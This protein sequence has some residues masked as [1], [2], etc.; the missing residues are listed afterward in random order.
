MKRHNHLF[1]KIIEEGNFRQAYCNAIKGKRHKKDVARFMVNWESNLETL[2]Q[3]VITETYKISKYH[4]FK[5]WSGHKWRDIYKLP[6]RDRIVQHAIMRV[7]KPLFI[8][9]FIKDT[10]SSI[11]GRGIHKGLKRVKGALT[12]VEG[13]QYCLK[14][15]VK[16]FYPNIDQTILKNKLVKRFKDKKLLRLL[17]EIIDSHPQG[18]PI[19][20]YTSQYFANFFLSDTDHYIKETLQVKYYFRYCD[21]IVVLGPTKEYLRTVLDSLKAR[22]T[23][24]NLDIKP[25]Y[26]IFPV[27]SRGVDFL[28]YVSYHT[29]IRIRKVTKKHFIQKKDKPTS[30]ASYKGMLMHADCRNLWNKYI[31]SLK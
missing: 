21:D 9:M 10:Y 31:K 27:T 28:G 17:V 16:K 1:S 22:L 26:Q 18:V 11:E 3:E 6:I 2:R 25:N 23:I 8:K 14:I 19:G 7:L 12:D 24:D 4:H 20:N 30:V 13:T 15:D 29:H 5:L